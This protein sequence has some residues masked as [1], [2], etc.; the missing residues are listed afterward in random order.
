MGP[1]DLFNDFSV[2]GYRVV[3]AVGGHRTIIRVRYDT[4]KKNG[5][6]VYDFDI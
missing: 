6:R 1:L 5:S 4:D 3:L 2:R